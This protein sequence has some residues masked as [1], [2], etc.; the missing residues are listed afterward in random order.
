MHLAEMARARRRAISRVTH[1]GVG[2]VYDER[3]EGR[4]I[5]RVT[6]GDVG[7]ACVR[8]RSSYLIQL[9]VVFCGSG[10]MEVPEIEQTGRVWAFKWR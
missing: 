5:T 6:N 10:L 2:F 4:P 1:E 9:E 8:F 3:P 7:S